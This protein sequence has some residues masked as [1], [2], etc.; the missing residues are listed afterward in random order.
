MKEPPIITKGRAQCDQY[1]AL[2]Q[3]CMRKLDTGTVGARLNELE[4][5]I[6]ESDDQAERI[7]CM[8]E[9][10]GFVR[11]MLDDYDNL[12]AEKGSEG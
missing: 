1:S 11:T 3:A 12:V 9:L 4:T 10:I 7:S 5:M 8:A 2:L 6:H